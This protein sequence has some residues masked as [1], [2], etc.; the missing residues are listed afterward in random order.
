MAY[1]FGSDAIWT[2]TLSILILPSAEKCENVLS[3]IV[4]D[5]LLPLGVTCHVVWHL[6]E[7]RIP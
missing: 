1:R 3:V 7:K 6:S 5:K 2:P 4:F